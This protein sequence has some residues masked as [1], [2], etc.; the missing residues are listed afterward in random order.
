M[1]LGPSATQVWGGCR[2]C[3]RASC[4]RSSWRMTHWIFLPPLLRALIGRIVGLARR[5]E[6]ATS[7][8]I[9]RG[10]AGG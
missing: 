1:K 8:A 5:D 9:A 6:R 4:W 10:S 7:P 3:Q 2:C